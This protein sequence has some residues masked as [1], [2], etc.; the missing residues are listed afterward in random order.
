MRK[1]AALWPWW[2]TKAMSTDTDR[3]P[4]LAQLRIPKPSA[5]ECWSRQRTRLLQGM[6]AEPQPE[7]VGEESIWGTLMGNTENHTVL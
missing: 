4:Q 5:G 2:P 1:A 7:L 6:P 3:P